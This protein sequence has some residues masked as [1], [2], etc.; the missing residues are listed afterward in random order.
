MSQVCI[1]AALAAMHVIGV[2]NTLPWK[3]S[4]DLKR[5]KA[6]TSGNPII[7]GRKT[8]DSVGGKPLPNR[9]NIVIS[10]SIPE[11]IPE[12][13]SYFT[14]LECAIEFARTFNTQEIF[15]IGGQQIYQQALDKKLVDKMYLTQVYEIFPE[16]DAFFPD[17]DNGD[18]KCILSEYREEEFDYCFQDYERIKT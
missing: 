2:N 3:I 15:I 8:F 7:M 9:P 12:N 17:W 18:W 1:I 6:L 13:V 4:N 10:R 16:G 11:C 14:S 5:F